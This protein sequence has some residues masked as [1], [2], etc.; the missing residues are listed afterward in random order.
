MASEPIKNEPQERRQPMQ[1][2]AETSQQLGR[3]EAGIDNTQED[4]RDI[5]QDVR[6]L[7]KGYANLKDRVGTLEGRQNGAPR[8]P[9]PAPQATP[10]ATPQP[11][12]G[13]GVYLSLKAIIALTT[14]LTALVGLAT[15]WAKAGFPIP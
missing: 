3:I 4:V 2:D 10:Q 13:F 14:V 11:R 12:D 5:K 7:T 9:Q 8:P 15:V 1:L 6:V